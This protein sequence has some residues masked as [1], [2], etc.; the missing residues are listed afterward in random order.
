MYPY[1]IYY[2]KV[3]LRANHRRTTLFLEKADLAVT[4]AER[5]IPQ[6]QAVL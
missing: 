2:F 3:G 4:N 1:I 6:D 5:T